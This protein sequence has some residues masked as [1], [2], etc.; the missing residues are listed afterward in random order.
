MRTTVSRDE[1]IKFLERACRNWSKVPRL[2]EDD[3]AD[4]A[5]ELLRF[6]A[7][8]PNTRAVI[9]PS[10]IYAALKDWYGEDDEWSHKQFV[11]MEKVV[12]SAIATLQGTL[13]AV[14][15]A[16]VNAAE[17]DAVPI[18]IRDFLGRVQGICMG[19]AM[20][21]RDHPNPDGALM[22]LYSEAQEILFPTALVRET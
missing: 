11:A 4:V 3:I 10:V 19:I 8:S 14:F 16:E 20:S 6:V 1:A 13:P 21:G 22:E 2:S 17:A 18:H 15:A 5:S 9:P 12:S 7:S